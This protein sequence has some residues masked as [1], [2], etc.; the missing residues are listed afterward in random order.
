VKEQNEDYEILLKCSNV[1]LAACTTD[2]LVQYR[3][4]TSNNSFRNAEKNFLENRLIY[5]EFPASK[6]VTMAIERNEIR[7]GLFKLIYLK[8]FAGL[9]LLFRKKSFSLLYKIFYDRYFKKNST[10]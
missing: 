6:N 5:R 7:Y 3:I 8:Q 1:S 2:S 9:K 10:I 4:H